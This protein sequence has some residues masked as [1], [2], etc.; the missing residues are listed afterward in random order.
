[1][2]WRRRDL[3]DEWDLQEGGSG[4]CGRTGSNRRAVFLVQ[5]L[6]GKRPSLFPP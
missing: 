3:Q 6:R 4:V 5:L 2:K 1:V